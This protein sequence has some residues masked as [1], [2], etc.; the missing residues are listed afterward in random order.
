MAALRKL[1]REPRAHGAHR[2]DADA[3]A[4]RGCRSCSHATWRARPPPS[5]AP[6]ATGCRPDRNSIPTVRSSIIL[7][8]ARIRVMSAV[9]T[10]DG[11]PPLLVIG[12]KNYSSWSL[13]PWLFL[14]KIGFDFREQVIQFD[15]PDY[16]AQIARFSPSRRVPLLIDGEAK[17][18]DSLA[19][20]E[21]AA[22]RMARGL[23]KNATARALARSVAAEMHSGFQA[24]RNECPMNI[25]ARERRVPLTPQLKEDIARIDEIWS[26]CRAA[27]WLRRRLAVRRVQ[28][29]RRDVRPGGISL[30]DLWRRVESGL[31]E[32]PAPRA[33][34]SDDARMAAGRGRRKATR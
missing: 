26:D 3:A 11:Q 18:W 2:L 23:P 22:E 28:R 6:P 32:L 20:C 8:P 17:I 5:R 30:S 4:C 29:G 7:C 19:I 13:R 1:F 33:R 14:R 27:V 15:A 25:R 34:G 12:S 16:Q 24:L 21:Y 10:P 9:A 31:A